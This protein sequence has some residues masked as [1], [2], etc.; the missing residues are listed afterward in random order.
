[1]V[2]EEHYNTARGVQ[3]VAGYRTADIIA[4]LGMDELS[5]RINRSCTAPAKKSANF[6]SQPFNCAKVLHRPGGR[7]P[8]EHRA[9]EASSRRYD[10][11]P[12][13]AF[14][15]VG[16][17]EKRSPRRKRCNKG[18]SWPKPHSPSCGHRQRRGRDFLRRREDVFAPG[19]RGELGLR[20]ACAALTLLKAA[21]CGCS[22]GRRGTGFLCRRR[23]A[24][25]AAAQDHGA[26]DTALR[27]KDLDESPALAAKQ[28]AEEA[29]KDNTDKISQARR[30][31]NSRARRRS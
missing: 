11:L 10:S 23:C 19:D 26:A 18:K 9:Q 24:R 4:I 15:M 20:A 30:W 25:G 29:L 3:G 21:R 8:Q 16:G 12:E 13:Q 17:I 31:P 6:L 7:E 2:G 22:P 5:A 1:V 27:A 14:Y 28:R